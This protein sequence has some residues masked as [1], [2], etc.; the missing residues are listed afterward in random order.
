M[1]STPLIGSGDI[2]VGAW[3]NF[4]RNVRTYAQYTVWFT[5]LRVVQ[6]ALTLVTAQLITLRSLRLLADTLCALPI[7]LLYTAL[8]ISLIETIASQ[9]RD[10]STGQRAAITPG[11][12][13]LVPMV[14]VSILVTAIVVPGLFLFLIP[15]FYFLVR[16]RFSQNFVILDGLRGRAALAASRALVKGRWWTTALRLALPG[17]FYT[18]AVM[19]VTYLLYFIASALLGDSA[20]FFGQFTAQES[21]S[22]SHMLVQ[23][24]LT[25]AINGLALPLYLAADL[26]LWH[27]LKRVPVQTQT[28]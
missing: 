16:Y 27:D 19:F 9:L 14:W 3:R 2:I 17:I 21:L 1:A 8:I 5:L 26:I 22:T 20:A 18:I 28:S 13:K 11:L 12:R 24:I 15:G 4:H 10:G 23:T 25:A 6:W 7:L